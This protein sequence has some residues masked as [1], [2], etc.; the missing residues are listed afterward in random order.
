MSIRIPLSVPNFIGNEKKYV[1]EAVETEWVSTGGAFINTFETEI[2]KYVKS[3][4]AVSCQNGTS[5]LHLGL[6]ALGIQPGDEVIVPALTFIASVNPV[7]YLKAKPI[8]IDC[9]ET[10]T[11]DPLK[12]EKFITEKCELH[13]DKLINKDTGGIVKA[14]M[15]VHI[16]GNMCDMEKIMNIAYKYHLKVIEDACE[17]IGTYYKSGKFKGRFAGTIGDIGVYSFNG[18]KIITTGGGGMIVSDNV[19]Y[20]NEMKHLSTQAKIDPIYYVHDQVGYNYR[21]TNLQAALGLAQLENLE[22]FI[23]IKEENYRYYINHFNSINGLQL[24]KFR[25]DIRPN[26]WF[27]SMYIENGSRYERDSMLITLKEHGIE[28]RPI[29][30]LVCD[31][32]PYQEASRFEIELAPKF[33]SHILNIPCSTNLSREQVDEIMRVIKSI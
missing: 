10:L 29:W 3:S 24:L 1:D 4:G 18:N 14:I 25:E 26:Y 16:F 28:T 21:M 13:D 22:K 12:I 7:T 27:Y 9:D 30:A 31:Q 17:A 23:N 19:N 2:A 32:K 33:I 11:I 6:I 15:P 5:G 20:L 8:F